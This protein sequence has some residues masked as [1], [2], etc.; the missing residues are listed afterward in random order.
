M[1]S[2][3]QLSQIGGVLKLGGCGLW[4]HALGP[5]TC[6]LSQELLMEGRIGI[7]CKDGMEVG[8]PDISLCNIC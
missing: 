3:V 5:C 8:L 7:Y 4:L 2:G 6:E 1:F